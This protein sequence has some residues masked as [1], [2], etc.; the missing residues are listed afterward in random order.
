[1]TYATISV[2]CVGVALAVGAFAMVDGRTALGVSV[3]SAIAVANLAVFSR[4]VRGL[5]GTGKHRRLWV[6]VGIIKIFALFGGVWWL[7][8][9]QVASGLAMV[10]GYGSLPLGIS[11]G[12]LLAPKPD[13]GGGGAPT[14]SEPPKERGRGSNDGSRPIDADHAG[15]PPHDLIMADSQSKVPKPPKSPSGPP[16]SK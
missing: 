4:V 16:T 5:L 13:A 11:I 6:L 7:L 14:Q 15:F 1:M 10:V 8:R 12:G 3:G 9:A 2:G